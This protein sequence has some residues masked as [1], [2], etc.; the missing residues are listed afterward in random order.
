MAKV[1]TAAVAENLSQI[2]EQHQLLPRNHFGGRLGQSTI[3]TVYYLTNRISM[4][5]RKNKV[6]SALSL[7]IEGA[8]ANVILTRLIHNLKKRRI[9]TAIINF[10]KTLLTNRRTRLK[11]NDF[12]SETISVTNRIGQGDPLSMLLYIL[13]NT[14]LL[15]IPT[16]TEKKDAIG[17]VDDT[18][19][20]AIAESFEGTTKILEKMMTREEGGIQWS[21]NY[22]SRFEVY[23]LA[24]AHFS[25]K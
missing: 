8:L 17:Y 7:D 13:Y 25:R 4:A 16:N 18:T 22:N 10:M 12:L 3:D 19:L 14:D 20:L 9:S 6:V 24:I 5:W 15:E 1:L 2:V 11:F 23:K 21:N